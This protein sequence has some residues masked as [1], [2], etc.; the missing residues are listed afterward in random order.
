MKKSLVLTAVTV[1]VLLNAHSGSAEDLL[2]YRGYVMGT[3]LSHV[4]QTGAVAAVEART[5]HERPSKI[6]SLK[7]RALYRPLDAVDAD[8]VRDIL[9]HF[10]DDALYQMVVT[11]DNTRVEGLTDGD[12][13]GALSGVYGDPALVGRGVVARSV[14]PGVELPPDTL[15]VARWDTA[16]SS[17]MLIRGMFSSGVQLVLTSKPLY[18]AARDAIGEAVRLDAGEAPQ[19]EIDARTRQATAVAAARAKARA[20]NKAAFRP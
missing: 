17:V 20:Q 5:T 14:S 7:W 12:L 11:Y 8:P 9:F 19:R 2:R 3:S 10:A 18:T 4:A 1:S 13:I 15:V 6:Q 16:L